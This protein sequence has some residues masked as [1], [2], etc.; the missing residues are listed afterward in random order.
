MI[1]NHP[2]LI[3]WKK[4]R[5]LSFILHHK[6][7][8]NGAATFLFLKTNIP[9]SQTANHKTDGSEAC[10]RYPTWV[11]ERTGKTGRWSTMMNVF[12]RHNWALLPKQH[13]GRE[14]NTLPLLNVVVVKEKFHKYKPWKTSRHNKASPTCSVVL[15]FTVFTRDVK[16]IRYVS[17]NSI[18]KSIRQWE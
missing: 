6:F 14:I 8:P 16:D 18:D 5:L 10:V 13:K 11:W 2:F 9:F 15:D 4:N 17:T 1:P 7:L 12:V 3:C